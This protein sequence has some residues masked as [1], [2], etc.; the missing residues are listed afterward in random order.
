LFVA[1]PWRPR[2]FLIMVSSPSV[3]GEPSQ[4]V[5]AARPRSGTHA[6]IWATIACLFLVSSAVVRFIQ[7]RRHKEE[8]NW[9]EDCPF[10]LDDI[11]R[12]LGHWTNSVDMP[13]LDS[14]TMLITGGKTSIIRTY[15]D[16][17]TGVR[18]VV[19][20]LFGPTEPVIPHVPEVC[21]P[22]N[23]FSKA[24]ESINRTIKY[25]FTDASGKESAE[26]SADFR[27]A[28]YQKVKILEGVYYSFRYNGVWS[29]NIANGQKLPRRT[30]GVFKVQI[31]RLMIPGESRDIDKYPDPIEDFLKSLLPAMEHEISVG[32]AKQAAKSVASG[33]TTGRHRPDEI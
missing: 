13:K 6:V 25:T 29:P 19:L 11:P 24:D 16:E 2:G 12:T 28:V 14:K 27:S 23:G 9:T 20:V 15:T 30:P 32:T 5:L 1:D 21:Y 26:Q 17:S 22:A 4:A 10:P 8:S 3:E 7:D 33:G 31:Q 18:L